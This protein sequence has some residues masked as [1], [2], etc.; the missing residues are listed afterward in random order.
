MALPRWDDSVSDQSTSTPRPH[1]PWADVHQRSQLHFAHD[2]RPRMRAAPS[3]EYPSQP[4]D[5]LLMLR[6]R[7][8]PL[9]HRQRRRASP[10]GR[11][12]NSSS[13][14][15]AMK[16]V[17]H[18]YHRWRGELRPAVPRRD[19]R[20]VSATVPARDSYRRPGAV[21]DPIRAHEI[22]WKDGRWR[23]GR[24]TR[25]GRRRTG[26]KFS[27]PVTSRVSVSGCGDRL[28]PLITTMLS[29][30]DGSRSSQNCSSVAFATSTTPYASAR[31]LPPSHHAMIRA[32]IT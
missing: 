17:R 29:V 25:S 28:K 15:R 21:V 11:L 1:G 13:P 26:R 6:A 30:A 7:R 16:A 24:R 4:D 19:D 10:S 14:W 22:C 23:R 12:G 31:A 8:G 9:G 3:L 20:V 27:G 18:G 5:N 2:D 32:S